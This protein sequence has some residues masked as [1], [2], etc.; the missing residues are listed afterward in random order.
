MTWRYALYPCTPAQPL[1]GVLDSLEEKC[2]VHSLHGAIQG[3]IPRP[4]LDYPQY[5]WRKAF[6]PACPRH[7]CSPASQ[8][9]PHGSLHPTR[10]CGPSGWPKL[11]LPKGFTPP[12]P[13]FVLPLRHDSHIAKTDEYHP[14]PQGLLSTRRAKP[15]TSC[16]A[17]RKRA[18]LITRRSLDRN[19]LQLSLFFCIYLCFLLLGPSPPPPHAVLYFLRM[20][21][22]SLTDACWRPLLA[23]RAAV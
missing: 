1:A 20:A 19:E 18:G 4:R 9:R 2:T 11:A 12:P 13:S 6:C 10:R 17:Q 21:V 15:E 14:H 8:T 16:M 3:D 22:I 7:I 5:R 23:P